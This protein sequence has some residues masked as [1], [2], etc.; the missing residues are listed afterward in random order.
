MSDTAQIERG[1]ERVSAPAGGPV[2][3]A[4]EAALVPEL[5]LLHARLGDHGVVNPK[6][7]P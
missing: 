2:E 7:K 1:S 6:P 3:A 4:V 5:V